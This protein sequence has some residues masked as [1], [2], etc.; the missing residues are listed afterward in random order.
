MRLSAPIYKLKRQAKMSARAQGIPL[1]SALDEVAVA[2]GFRSWSH[3]SA[4]MPGSR[5]AP[6]VL[7]KLD[8]GDMVLLGAR[9]GQGKTLLGLE[10]ALAS[11]KTGFAGYFFTLEYT[12]AAV[13]DRL[14]DLGADAR[15]TDALVIDTS[16]QICADHIIARVGHDARALV[17][18]DYLQLLDQKRSLPDLNAQVAALSDFARSSGA[19]IVAISQIDRAFDVAGK[20]LPDHTDIR[21]PNPVDLARFTKRCFLHEGELTL[22]PAA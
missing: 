21:L 3:L 1:H 22:D 17:V 9:P 20:R 15:D 10:L 12:Q 2:N 7:G 4:A 14:A 16:D 6:Q 13:R 11:A 19:I 8:R 5:L 18:I